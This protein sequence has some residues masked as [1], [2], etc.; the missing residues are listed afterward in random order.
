MY[1]HAAVATPADA[2]GSRIRTLALALAGLILLANFSTHV[3]MQCALKFRSFTFYFS[4]SESPP[5]GSKR[6]AT[7]A[8]VQ[9][10]ISLHVPVV[11]HLR[12]LRCCGAGAFAGAAALA[13]ALAVFWLYRR[14][15][16]ASST[17]SQ[18]MLLAESDA[19]DESVEESLEL[20]TNG[21]GEPVELGSGSHGK[22]GGTSALISF[23]P[24]QQLSSASTA[25]CA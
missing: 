5:I 2:G 8:A 15:R 7:T 6:R 1:V 9:A 10:H 20:V 19:E 4:G 11:G 13:V 18:M 21:R 22:V 16:Q 23:P 24:A 17:S 3:H 25:L 14:N 12:I